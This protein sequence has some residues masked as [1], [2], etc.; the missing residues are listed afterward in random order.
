MGDRNENG[1]KKSYLRYTLETIPMRVV[2]GLDIRVGKLKK[3][4]V[5]E[6]EIDDA[7][8]KGCL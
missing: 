5:S 6:E 2:D 7:R 8:Q 3:W 4:H 1:E